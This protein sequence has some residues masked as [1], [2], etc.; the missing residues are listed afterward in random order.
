MNKGLPPVDKKTLL[1]MREIFQSVKA[2]GLSV[3]A[4]IHNLRVWA[5]ANREDARDIQNQQKPK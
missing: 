4:A 2:M 1:S 3:Q 5:K